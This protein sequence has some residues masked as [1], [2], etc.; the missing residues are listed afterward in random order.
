M[1]RRIPEPSFNN[2]TKEDWK[3]L[4]ER[5][6]FQMKGYILL[7]LTNF[8]NAGEPKVMQGSRV[9]ICGKLYISQ[10]DEDI[11][12]AY[13]PNVWNF[14][15]AVPNSTDTEIKYV[16]ST[17]KPV[18]NV[19]KSGWMDG[20]NRAVAKLFPDGNGGFWDK[21]VL[22][23]RKRMFD[24]NPNILPTFGGDLVIE[25]DDVNAIETGRLSPGT[26]YYEVTGALGGRGGASGLTNW[27]GNN[28]EGVNGDWGPA[29]EYEKGAFFLKEYSVVE[30]YKGNDGTAGTRGGSVPQNTEGKNHTGGGGGSGKNGRP[31]WLF[32]EKLNKLIFKLG[33][34]GGKGADA[35]GL[36]K[37][38]SPYNP[39]PKGGSA[40]AKDTT[41]P[42]RSINFPTN[43]GINGQSGTHANS[44]GGTG[45]TTFTGTS[46]GSVRIYKIPVP[47]VLV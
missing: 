17:V 44:T 9:E 3:K 21:V 28:L 11:S 36:G 38:T 33:G 16:V 1:V 22:D 43:N 32:I 2:P 7:G 40:P 47:V 6:R 31:S 25:A 27:E 45:A 29:G 35:K 13:T 34:I 26:Y 37:I 15:Y 39:G 23:H 42:S 12:G 41:T 46:S 30:L 20:D 19:R 18:H 24:H 4:V 10:E 5:T 14:I 8:T